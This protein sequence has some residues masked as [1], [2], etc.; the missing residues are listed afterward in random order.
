MAALDLEERL[1]DLR[2]T[3]DRTFA[4]SPVT[5]TEETLDLLA[6]R[7]AGAPYAFR[8]REIG[9]LTTCKK[10]APLPTRRP[11]LLGVAGI[12]GSLVLVYDLST[13]LGHG[14][15]EASPPWLA[16]CGSPEPIALGFAELEGF[17]RVRLADIH[18]SESGTGDERMKRPITA[19]ARVNGVVRPIVDIPSA[20][21]AL[22]AHAGAA[23]PTEER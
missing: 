7:V 1:A 2:R 12:R 23:G 11:E 21:D 6:I 14:H 15:V 16:L 9:G 13:L 10:L 4:A 20:M 18:R 3:F 8:A 17:A 19:V 5:V 22:K